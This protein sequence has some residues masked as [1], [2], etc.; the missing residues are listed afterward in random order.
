M[1]KVDL[2]WE[3]EHEG[4]LDDQEID[5]MNGITREFTI[6]DLDLFVYNKKSKEFDKDC[7]YDSVFM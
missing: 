5:Q 3:V 7:S 1:S 6:D 2:S 4:L